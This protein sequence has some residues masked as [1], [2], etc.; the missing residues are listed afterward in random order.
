MKCFKLVKITRLL[1]VKHADGQSYL[2]NY[3]TKENFLNG[4]INA[5]RTNIICVLCKSNDYQVVQQPF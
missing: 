4:Q 2:V 1:L 5:I 3:L